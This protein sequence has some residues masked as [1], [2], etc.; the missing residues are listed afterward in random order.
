MVATSLPRVSQTGGSCGSRAG[1]HPRVGPMPTGPTTVSSLVAAAMS[2]PVR[3]TKDIGAWVLVGAPMQEEAGEWSFRTLSARTVRDA[4]GA[5]EAVLDDTY[6]VHPLKK[7]KAGPFAGTVLI[8]RSRTNDV[9]VAHSSVS[10]LHA[11]IRT[12]AAGLFLSDAGSSNGTFFNNERLAKDAE[13]RIVHA[14]Q[15]RFGA[16]SFQAFEPQR[17]VQLLQKFS[18]STSG[19]LPR[20]PGPRD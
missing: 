4:S 3:L 7:Q 6:L 12:D 9:C 16:C 19:P 2:D 17:F 14:A 11:R 8:G 18:S 1:V 13:A 10:K 15:L 20:S 5:V